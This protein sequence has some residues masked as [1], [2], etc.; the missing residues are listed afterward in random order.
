MKEVV[1]VRKKS[2]LKTFDCGSELWLHIR[3][4]WEDFKIL[5][6]N[7]YPSNMSESLEVGP[8]VQGFLQSSL[9][10]SIVQP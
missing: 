6:F 2:I 4:I 10:D 9:N 3:I 8:Q 5:V 1:S 7:L